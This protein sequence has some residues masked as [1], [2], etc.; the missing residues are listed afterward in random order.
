MQK[1]YTYTFPI[2]ATVANS[3]L[4]PQDLEREIKNA[5]TSSGAKVDKNEVAGGVR[6][7]SIRMPTDASEARFKLECSELPTSV[8]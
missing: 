4:G 6:T 8:L 2:G 3:V 5:A 1:V 7:M